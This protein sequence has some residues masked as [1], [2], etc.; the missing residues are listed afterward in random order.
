[1]VFLKLFQSILLIMWK[2]LSV[3]QLF[4]TDRAVK[5]REKQKHATGSSKTEGP[6]LFSE[7]KA[8]SDLSPVTVSETL[9]AQIWFLPL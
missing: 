2:I 3:E 7:P 5:E 9:K 4:S 1:M 8:Q 6:Y